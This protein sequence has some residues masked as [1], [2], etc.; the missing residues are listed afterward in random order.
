VHFVQ[1]CPFF[2]KTAFQPQIFRPVKPNLTNI[3]RKPQNWEKIEVEDTGI[4]SRIP[5]LLILP[6]Q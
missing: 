4:Q 3:P 1:K 2:A 5:A 6:T